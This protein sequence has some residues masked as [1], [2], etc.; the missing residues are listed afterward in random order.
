MLNKLTPRLMLWIG[1][2]LLFINGSVAYWRFNEAYQSA[3]AQSRQRTAQLAETVEYSIHTIGATT[4]PKALTAFIANM[5]N[6]SGLHT[7]AVIQPDD[8]VMAH[9]DPELV[10]QNYRY[11]LP[12][13]THE[14]IRQ[15]RRTGRIN[16]AIDGD[17][18]LYVIRPLTGGFFRTGSA[19]LITVKPE[20]DRRALLHSA[21]WTF[22][23]NIVATLIALY[24]LLHRQ[25]LNPLTLISNALNQ[26]GRQGGYHAPDLLPKNELQLLSDTV[27]NVFEK[28][29]H[30]KDAANQQETLMRAM[31][32][33]SPFGYLVIAPDKKS[34]LFSNIQCMRLWQFDE[35]T[36][37]K[38]IVQLDGV[39]LLRQM[40]A[41]VDDRD[42]DT[43]TT[44]FAHHDETI[45]RDDLLLADGRSIRC[46]VTAV[47]DSYFEQLG[48][49]LVF[50]D[51]S[52]EKLAEKKLFEAKIAAEDAA[53]AK[54]GFLATMSHEIR[55]PMNGVIGMTGLLL[56]TPMNDEQ[57]EY[58]HVI[59]QSGEALLAIINDI[60][61]FS[62]I[63]AA[64]LDLEQLPFEPL[65]LVEDVLALLSTSANGKKIEL[66]HESAYNLPAIVIGDPARLRQILINLIGNAI[67]FTERGSVIVRSIAEYISQNETCLRFE[68]QDTGIGMSEAQRAKLFQPFSQADS[69]TT[70][71]F[72]GTGLGLVIAQRL[73][74]AMNGYVEVE[75]EA[76]K[77]SLFRFYIRL[78]VGPTPPTESQARSLLQ[79]I[80]VLFVDDKEINR[81][82]LSAQ[83]RLIECPAHFV[84]NAFEAR[85]LLDDP[86]SKID[87]LI[88]D[89]HMP[90]E[91]GLS[92]TEY[93]RNIPRWQSLPVIILS[94]GH[95]S[96]DVERAKALHVFRF[97]QKPLRLK[98]L[99]QTLFLV[100]GENKPAATTI[101]EDK[102]FADWKWRVLV[103]EDNAINQ[104]IIAKLLDNLGLHAEIASNGAEALEML[105]QAPYDVVLMDC[106]MPEMDGLTA[107][108]LLREREQV[109][110]GERQVVI[111][112]TA[113]AMSSD[114]QQ[115]LDAGMDDFLTKPIRREAVADCLLYWRE[116]INGP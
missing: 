74:A 101:T 9:T 79:N 53:K 40:V 104:K 7:I 106:Q 69:S 83:M 3:L 61:D 116:K 102:R 17:E 11:V 70:R 59:R 76:G 36:A 94:S 85:K 29:Q 39:A 23:L 28:W 88:S 89:F 18:W 93:L 50:E 91:D 58:V 107:T 65:D 55:T 98:S 71:R 24:F 52:A 67:K 48:Q 60:L 41:R 14:L 21:L 15:F 99:Q 103:A 87:V 105:S 63:E 62:K 110:G 92:L 109:S 1:A 56:E 43:A 20:L 32:E 31:S 72:G 90:D 108:R 37:T 8:V 2:L 78:P 12:A 81:R 68:V 13:A 95:V 112:L 84:A 96:Q 38:P 73:C 10:G 27:A 46:L 86:A 54:A 19:V 4:S 51:V 44:L 5:A 49:L 22:A 111:A 113:N 16:E 75:S 66:L 25:V 80:H 47:I 26:S 34:V 6:L 77:G 115:C 97:L 57:K 35:D 82:T 100:T 30:S 114:K 64:K 42:R 45:K 33:S